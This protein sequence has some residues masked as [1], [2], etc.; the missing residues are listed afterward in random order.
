MARLVAERHRPNGPRWVPAGSSRR[1]CVY[2]DGRGFDRAADQLGA[3]R[4]WGLSGGSGELRSPNP[5]DPSP[6]RRPGLRVGATEVRK[7]VGEGRGSVYGSRLESH[8]PGWRGPGELARAASR[9][10]HLARRRAPCHVADSSARRGRS[11][12]ILAGMDRIRIS[13]PASSRVG[14]PSRTIKRTTRPMPMPALRSACRV[15]R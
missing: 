15:I 3:S 14:R 12:N 2:Q 10:R 4:R 7:A 13:V 9:R 11:S 1:E 6:A 5:S 8:G